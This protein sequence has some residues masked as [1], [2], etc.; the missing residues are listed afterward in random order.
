[1]A[2][3]KITKRKGKGKKTRGG[4]SPWWALAAVPVGYGAYKFYKSYKNN[5]RTQFN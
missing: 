5:E 2:T 3:R 1:M 4:I